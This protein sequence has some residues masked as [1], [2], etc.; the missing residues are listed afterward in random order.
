MKNTYT[1]S[2][3]LAFPVIVHFLFS[4]GDISPSSST[5]S[6]FIHKIPVTKKHYVSDGLAHFNLLQQNSTYLIPKERIQ[7]EATLTHNSRYCEDLTK[8]DPYDSGNVQMSSYLAVT[9]VE[10]K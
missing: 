8:T 2:Y 9:T 5:I 6:V 3:C 4:L 7:H 1:N 10:S